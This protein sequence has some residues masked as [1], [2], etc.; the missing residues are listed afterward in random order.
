M[1]TVGT[2]WYK[3]PWGIALLIAGAALLAYLGYFTYLVV[4]FTYQFKTQ[5][6]ENVK[7]KLDQ[8]KNKA[9]ISRIFAQKAA[10]QGTFDP[11]RIEAPNRPTLGNPRAK[12]RIVEFLD[13]GCPFCRQVEP[14]VQH[15]VNEHPDDV[16]LMLRDL[17]ITD[18]H[19]AAEDAAIAA[20][21]VWKQGDAKRFWRYHALLFA[22]QDAQDPAALRG[23]ASQVGADL[24]TY[25]VC[26]ASTQ[27]KDEVQASLDD[28][29]SLG[30]V[31]TPSFFFNGVPIQ[32]AMDDATFAFIVQEASRAAP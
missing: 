20:R 3:R 30:L 12:V 24:K 27:V 16:Y 15:Y 2:S 25:D 13:Y 7:A 4:S 23:Y 17:P 28:A 32:G 5:G 1:P 21:C 19:P 14:V 29:E 10:E 9:S 26:I 6:I 22:H 11:S 8:D 18:L 31:G